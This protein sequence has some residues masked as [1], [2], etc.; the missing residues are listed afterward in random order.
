MFVSVYNSSLQLHVFFGD[1]T[2]YTLTNEMI[3]TLTNTHYAKAFSSTMHDVCWEMHFNAQ[4]Q[5]NNI[6][7]HP[8]RAK[9]NRSYCFKNADTNSFKSLIKAFYCP[10]L[11]RST[12]NDRENKWIYHDLFSEPLSLDIVWVIT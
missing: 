8:F 5:A 4:Q 7:V 2:A 3:K 9:R 6:R 10:L 12:V 1:R 11:W